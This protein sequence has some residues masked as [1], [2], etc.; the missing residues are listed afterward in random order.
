MLDFHLTLI[1]K[2]IGLVRFNL[3]I[4]QCLFNFFPGNLSLV[5][6][7]IEC[8]CNDV[9]SVHLEELAQID[10]GI[11]SSETICSQHVIARWNETAN[12]IGIN[13]HVVGRGNDR[14]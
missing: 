13:L 8:R 11:R 2:R 7:R 5:L 12:L 9:V 6:Q 14:T 3:K 10:P 4:L 1:R